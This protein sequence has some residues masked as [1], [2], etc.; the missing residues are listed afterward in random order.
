MRNEQ[1][2]RDDGLFYLTQRRNTVRLVQLPSECH[3][4]E[5]FF[6]LGR[7]FLE[8]FT[9]IMVAYIFVLLGVVGTMH[10]LYFSG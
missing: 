8:L 2:K 1:G 3:L 7:S 4:R 5:G 9:T 10:H 6:R